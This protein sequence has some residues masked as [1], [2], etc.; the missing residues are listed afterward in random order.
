VPHLIEP[1]LCEASDACGDPQVVGPALREAQW[2][3]ASLTPAIYIR[4]ASPF[5]RADNCCRGDLWL[6]HPPVPGAAV[7]VA[8]AVVAALASR[9]SAL[10][11]GLA[12]AAVVAAVVL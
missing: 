4:W 3:A 11:A 8:A 7:M 12:E 9:R 2:S 10:D 6:W 5:C 1:Y